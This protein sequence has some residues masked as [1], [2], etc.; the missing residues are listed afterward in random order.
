[1]H[2]AL[3]WSLDM[4]QRII[5]NIPVLMNLIFKWGKIDRK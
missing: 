3:L 2:Q 4:G 5:K 1:M